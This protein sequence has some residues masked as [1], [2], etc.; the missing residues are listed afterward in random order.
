M[1]ELAILHDSIHFQ[2]RQDIS[3]LHWDLVQS[4]AREKVKDLRIAE[5]EALLEQATAP[6]A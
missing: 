6:D 4:K 1:D 5:L 2:H 3:N